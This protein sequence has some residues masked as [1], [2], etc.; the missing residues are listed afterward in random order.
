MGYNCTNDEIYAFGGGVPSNCSATKIN[1]LSPTIS[2]VCFTGGSWISED[3]ADNAIDNQGNIFVA[4]SSPPAFIDDTLLKVNS[5]FNG[6]SWI[7]PT[8]YTQLYELD[9]KYIYI[10]NSNIQGNGFNCLAVNQQYLY[11]YD[12]YNLAAYN[13]NTGLKI[14]FTVFSSFYP[15][16][17]GGIAVDRCNNVYIGAKDSVL[18]F[19]F[20]GTGFTALPLIQINAPGNENYV[21]DIKLNEN[22][23]ILYICGHEFVGSISAIHS[24]SCA[25]SDC[26]AE[27]NYFLELA[28]ESI[29]F[30]I[31][32]NPNNGSFTIQSTEKSDL[33]ILN[34]LGQTIK[35][36]H[37]DNQNQS[38]ISDLT[39]GVYFVAGSNFSLRKKIVV[40][41]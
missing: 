28:R 10:P 32:P 38:V 25:P 24:L 29:P 39:S 7:A 11:Y 2:P 6:N 8:T 20:S 31:F 21:Y 27:P 35:T 22:S 15:K 33:Y 9:N 16:A 3:I 34:A 23:D 41:K 30:Q 37:L 1:P 36:I 40:I 17:Q 4:F 26:A 12:G 19:N 5:Q 13:K 14:A 18:C